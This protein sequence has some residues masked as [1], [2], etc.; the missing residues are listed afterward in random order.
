MT[1]PLHSRIAG[2]AGRS[3]ILRKFMQY[4][5]EKENVWVATR[6]DIAKDYR[7]NFLT[8][9]ERRKGDDEVERIVERT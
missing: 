7:E 1:I 6:G 4:V 5:S 9:L 2:K 8:N 3:E